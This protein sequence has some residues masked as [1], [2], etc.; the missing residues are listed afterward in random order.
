MKSIVLLFLFGIFHSCYPEPRKKKDHQII[1][2]NKV[3]KRPI[4]DGQGNEN[5][6]NIAS[7]HRLNQN[8]LGGAYDQQDFNGRYKLNWD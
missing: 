6:W 5:S 3:S 7:W 1:E 2:V 8:W 4:I